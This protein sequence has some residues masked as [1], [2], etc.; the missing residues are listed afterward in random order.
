MPNMDNRLGTISDLHT[1][2]HRR[3]AAEGI[4][5]PYPQRDLHIVSDKRNNIPPTFKPGILNGDADQMT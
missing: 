4:E 5:I 3:F 1:E 2:I